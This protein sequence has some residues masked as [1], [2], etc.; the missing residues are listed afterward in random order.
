MAQITPAQAAEVGRAFL[1]HYYTVF[2]SNR[3]ALEP[4]YREQSMLTFQAQTVVGGKQI[5]AKLASLPFRTVAHR[6][7]TV[8]AQPSGAGPR[9][10]IVMVTGDMVIDQAASHKFT[11]VFHLVPHDA[12]PA[13]YWVHNDIF[14]T[15]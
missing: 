3:A 8:D 15:A 7:T 5:A 6:I 1:S 13:S 4:L 11:Q 12:N 2:G 14:R 9:G 10:V